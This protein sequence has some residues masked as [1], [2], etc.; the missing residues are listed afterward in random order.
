MSGT[1]LS[2]LDPKGSATI[3]QTY[4]KMDKNLHVSA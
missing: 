3:E 1:P 4:E 2:A